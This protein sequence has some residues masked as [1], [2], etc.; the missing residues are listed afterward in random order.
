MVI[1]MELQKATGS[2]AQGEKWSIEN[3]KAPNHKAV[4]SLEPF[5]SSGFLYLA[6]ELLSPIP[7]KCYSRVNTQKVTVIRTFACLESSRQNILVF[8]RAPHLAVLVKPT[9][10]CLVSW[11]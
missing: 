10:F 1:D 5:H 4:V 6:N 2:A 3:K 7:K 9:D 11:L 8:H